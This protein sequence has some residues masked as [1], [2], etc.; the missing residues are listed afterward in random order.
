MKRAKRDATNKK[1]K[2]IVCQE[3]PYNSLLLMESAS[4]NKQVDSNGYLN[5]D[6]DSKVIKQNDENLVTNQNLKMILKEIQTITRKIK[7][8]E[9]DEEK[10]LDWKF[11]AMVIDRLCLIIFSFA[12]FISTAVILLTAKNFFKFR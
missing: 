2:N 12:T 8:D 5:Y 7:G 9:E 1:N 3:Y 6:Y 4:L 10:S 11:A